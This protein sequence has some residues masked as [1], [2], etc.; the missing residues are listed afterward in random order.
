MVAVE[1]AVL[2]S[3]DRVDFL[4]AVGAD[5]ETAAR[6]DLLVRSRIDR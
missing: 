3:L 6:A 5:P 2:Y 1:D 4:D